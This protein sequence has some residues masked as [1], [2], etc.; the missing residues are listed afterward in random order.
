MFMHLGHAVRR[1]SIPIVVLILLGSCA[2]LPAEEAED[3][4]NSLYGSEYKK[5]LASPNPA[6][7]AA[8]AAQLLTGAKN[9]GI[10]PALMTVLCNKAYELGVKAPAGHE[11]AI[12]AMQLLAG[13]VPEH[14]AACLANTA[15]VRQRQFA[16]ATGPDRAGIGEN[17]I[18]SSLTAAAAKAK[19]GAAPEALA[20]CQQAMRIAVALKSDSKAEVQT[21][22][23]VV[24][25]RQR[26]WQQLAALKKQLEANPGD[27]AA[28]TEILRLLV[29]EFDDPAQ[30]AT[31]LNDT[32]DA[33][34][35]KYVPAIQKGIEAA[36]EA[37]CMELATWYLGLSEKASPIAK[38]QMMQR[39][40]AYY[41]KF[42]SLHAAQDE[43][44]AKAVLA[45]GKIE[46]ALPRASPKKPAA[47]ADWMDLLKLVNLPTHASGGWDRTDLGVL[48]LDRGVWFPCA[49]DG[50]YEV[51]F[52]LKMAEQSGESSRGSTIVLPVGISNVNLN[53]GV[54][55]GTTGLSRIK[56]GEGKSLLPPPP[57][58]PANQEVSV[59]I[60][61]IVQGDSADISATINGRPLCH[62]QGPI[63]AL[64]ASHPW[65][66]NTRCLGL[67]ALGKGKGTISLR[68]AKLRIVS[69]KVTLLK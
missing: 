24:T 23:D 36:P 3:T 35:L 46:A 56:P 31:F 21:M 13:K 66:T 40:L 10:T 38:A 32:C 69:G 39:A 5:V 59:G 58:L 42:L 8:L 43:D 14:Q 16:A 49:I 17:A 44:R 41:E 11:T 50:S 62:W 7:D 2:S 9:E 53:L 60:K 25:A 63:S 57:P 45:K 6:D 29:V 22:I 30:A 55:A 19:A 64:S 1:R 48:N 26:A 15:A 34:M 33:A 12:E 27:A 61:V 18:D 65:F 4:F 54:T 28:R 68:T 52:V 47:G 37:A 51:L 20:L 67:G